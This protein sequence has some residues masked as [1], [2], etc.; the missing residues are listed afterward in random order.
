[1]SIIR[2]VASEDRIILSCLGVF[3]VPFNDVTPTGTSPRSHDPLRGRAEGDGL[4]YDL[5][6]VKAGDD[7]VEEGHGPAGV[8][9]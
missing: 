9:G 2:V 7:S 6:S 1:M 4:D 8:A 5:G 3:Y